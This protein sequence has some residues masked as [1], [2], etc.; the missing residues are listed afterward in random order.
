MKQDKHSYRN[1]KNTKA[2][3]LLIKACGITLIMV[4]LLTLG[5]SFSEPANS[6]IG[7]LLQTQVNLKN[8]Q[9]A[10][11]TDERLQVMQNMG[12]RVDNLEQQRV[13]IHMQKLPGNSQLKELESMGVVLYLDSWI[14]PLENH[15]TGFLLADIPVDKLS[16]LATEDFIIRLETAERAFEPQFEPQTE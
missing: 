5:C 8:E 10:N 1:W 13:F 4:V 16:E 2:G 6:K 7:I 11:P 15:P 9:L 14:P 3:K 12:M